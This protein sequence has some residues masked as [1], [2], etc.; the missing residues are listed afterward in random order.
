VAECARP[1]LLSQCLQATFRLSA[2][3]R[4]R[5]GVARLIAVHGATVQGEGRSVGSLEGEQVGGRGGG[6]K[7]WWRDRLKEQGVAGDTYEDLQRRK[8]VLD[9]TTYGTAG[10]L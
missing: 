10:E 9:G 1:D 5:E 3:Q 6:E 7:P 2:A 8:R 4:D